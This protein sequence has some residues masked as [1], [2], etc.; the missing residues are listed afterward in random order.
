MLRVPLVVVLP[1]GKPG[2]YDAGAVTTLDVAKTVLAIGDAPAEEVMGVSLVPYAHFDSAAPRHAPIFAYGPKRAA[3]I[4]WPLKIIV[5]ERK[6]Q[7]RNF[8]FDLAID[9]QEGKDLSAEH[10]D[11]VTRLEKL[12]S[13][14]ATTP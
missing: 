11:D 5:Q 6:K 2:R 3:L 14:V 9:P 8:L 10:A 1:N 12:L 13:D 7:N 4:D